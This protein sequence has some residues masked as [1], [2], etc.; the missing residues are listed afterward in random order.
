MN[1][2]ISGHHIEVTPALREYVTTKLERVLKHA[3][4]V[5]DATVVLS[6]DNSKEKEL[7]QKVSCATRFKGNDVFVETADA[8]L[9]AAIDALSDKLARQLSRLKEK[10]TDRK[11]SA[12]PLKYME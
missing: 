1:L 9:Y 6:V 10:S 8:D 5:L 4:Q 3:D 7:R 2:T 11:R 12:E